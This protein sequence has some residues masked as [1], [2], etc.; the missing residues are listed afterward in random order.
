MNI[1]RI[2]LFVCLAMLATVPVH[3]DGMSELQIS[4]IDSQRKA[5]AFK[6]LERE[7]KRLKGL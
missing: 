7:V 1:G 2:V 6:E 3:A 5:D 4:A